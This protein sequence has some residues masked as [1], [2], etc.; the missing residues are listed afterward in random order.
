M[1][2]DP[3]SITNHQNKTPVVRQAEQ[4]YG[5]RTE[6]LQNFFNH[7]PKLVYQLG[8]MRALHTRQP[9]PSLPDPP[10]HVQA[11]GTYLCDNN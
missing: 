1:K 9:V 5:T 2:V 10:Q 11:I 4:L 8:L 3:V 7:G 6:T